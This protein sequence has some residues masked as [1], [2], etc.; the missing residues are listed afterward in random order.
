MEVEGGGYASGQDGCGICS[1]DSK[2]KYLETP[3]R[4]IQGTTF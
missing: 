2:K 3:E 1:R 4:G